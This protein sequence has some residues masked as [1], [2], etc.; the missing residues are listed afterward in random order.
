[1]HVI[2]STPTHGCKGSWRSCLAHNY[3]KIFIS[4]Q[5]IV[6]VFT[7]LMHSKDASS[8]IIPKL[9]PLISVQTMT[10]S[11]PLK[12]FDPECPATAQAQLE[13]NMRCVLA[14]MQSRNIPQEPINLFDPKVPCRH[15]V[16]FN[17]VDTR[18]PRQFRPQCLL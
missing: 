10:T 16:R 4:I 2:L 7:C 13:C 17:C 12:T 3:C 5:W 11:T 6:V 8:R 14:L 1:M 9:F 15:T 18:N